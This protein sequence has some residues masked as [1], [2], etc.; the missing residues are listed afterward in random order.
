MPTCV[1]QN[2]KT[3]WFRLVNGMLEYYYVVDEEQFRLKGSINVA[4]TR[5]EALTVDDYGKEHSFCVTST[6][7]RDFLVAAAPTAEKQEWW[8]R[9]LSHVSKCALHKKGTLEKR[10][11]GIRKVRCV[12]RAVNISSPSGMTHLHVDPAQNWK[13]RFMVLSGPELLYFNQEE[14]KQLGK[15]LVAGAMITE[16]LPGEVGGARYAFE[17]VTD[18]KTLTL[19]V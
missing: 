12:L 19:K 10:M 5:V 11:G 18:S 6:F 9:V 7:N 14:G 1:L 8:V 13:P 15:V 16:L 2:W 4:A 17:V 3:R